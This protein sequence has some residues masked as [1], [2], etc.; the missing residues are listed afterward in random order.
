MI[1]G[2]LSH[3]PPPGWLGK[4]SSKK[5]Y[6]WPTAIP[7]KKKQISISTIWYCSPPTTTMIP[8][9][10]RWIP[11]RSTMIELPSRSENPISTQ[12]RKGAWKFSRPKKFMRTFGFRRLH[13]YTSIIVKAWPRNTRLTKVPNIWKLVKENANTLNLLI[14]MMKDKLLIG[15]TAPSRNYL[16]AFYHYV[17]GL[18]QGVGDT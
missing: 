9:W 17:R 10:Q 14:F 8:G 15:R 3:L 7:Q 12:G 16:I 4:T 18:Q 5:K 2:V 13:T 6:T 1:D 11:K